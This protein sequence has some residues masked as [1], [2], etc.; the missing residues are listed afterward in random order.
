MLE[1][2]ISAVIW[3]VVNLIVLYLL[4][5]KLLFKPVMNMIESRQQE[6][7]H[8]IA[9]AEDQRIKAEAMLEE[10]DGKLKNAHHEA[11]Q[12]VAQAKTRA[13]HE[14][15]AVI[16][17]AQLDSKRLT[18]ESERQIENE[19]QTMLAGVRKEV[20]TLAL[21][22]AARVSAHGRNSEED[23]ALLESFLSEVGDPS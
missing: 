1:F 8:N 17:R 15:Q 2:D 3:T 4:L 12:L 22:A 19:R 18:E 7:D 5:K 16:K 11:S 21:M 10:Y 14:Y 6:I 9:A 13:E 20:A 23:D